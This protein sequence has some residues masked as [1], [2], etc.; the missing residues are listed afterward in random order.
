MREYLQRPEEGLRPPRSWSY[1][2]LYGVLYESRNL[3]LGP[4]EEYQLITDTKPF[5]Q[6]PA[7]SHLNNHCSVLFL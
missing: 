1:R 6:P 5:L 4:Q 3:N 2:E 7:L